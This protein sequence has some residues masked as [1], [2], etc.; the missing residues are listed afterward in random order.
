MAVSAVFALAFRPR[1]RHAKAAIKAG[2]PPS[3]GRISELT[4]VAALS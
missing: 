3:G 1:A 4:E 2:A